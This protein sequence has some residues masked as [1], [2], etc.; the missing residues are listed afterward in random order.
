MTRPPSRRKKPDTRLGRFMDANDIGVL[1]LESASGVTRQT[2]T[3]LRFREHDRD[4]TRRVMVPLLR[5]VRTL[6][7]D[8][9]VS[10]TD[11]FD[12]EDEANE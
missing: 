7:P 6:L 3:R 4:A 12:F 5:G 9:P 8:R 2:V 10:I 11:L 1:E